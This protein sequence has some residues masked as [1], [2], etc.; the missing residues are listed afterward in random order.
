MC[1]IVTQNKNVAKGCNQCIF[2][3]V[4]K[5][6]QDKTIQMAG[7]KSPRYV[8]MLV[9]Y[10]LQLSIINS[11]KTYYLFVQQ[12]SRSLFIGN[13]MIFTFSFLWISQTLN[14]LEI[15]QIY[16]KV[17]CLLNHDAFPS[18]YKPLPVFYM[19]TIV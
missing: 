7:T 8:S 1:L 14:H 4:G 17:V 15:M 10:S 6:H 16:A 2:M 5:P 18:T 19:V 9:L 11:I 13:F 12:N 3:V